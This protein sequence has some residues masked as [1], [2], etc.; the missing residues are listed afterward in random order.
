MNRF[1]G[2]TVVITGA[3][4]GLG[5]GTAERVAEEGANVA[6]VDLNGE[7][8]EEV[9]AAIEGAGATGRVIIKTANVADEAEVNAYVAAAVDAFG[10]IDGFFNNAGIEGRQN[11]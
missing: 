8:L 10:A 5:R 4:S 7:R 6:L 1:D 9:K 11:L 2:K 3:A